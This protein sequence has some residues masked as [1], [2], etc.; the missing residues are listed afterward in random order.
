MKVKVILD[1][2]QRSTNDDAYHYLAGHGVQVTWSSP[3][4]EYTHQKTIVIDGKS[5]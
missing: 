1:R 2:Q 5:R 3:A 4:F